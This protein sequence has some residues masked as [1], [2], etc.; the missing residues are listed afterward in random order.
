MGRGG[1]KRQG[2]QRIYMQCN[3]L[4]GKHVLETRLNRPHFS[5]ACVRT[6]QQFLCVEN[7]VSDN[8][9]IHVT[10]H[11]DEDVC[12]CQDDGK[13]DVSNH[14]PVCDKCG[15]YYGAVVRCDA[16]DTICGVDNYEVDNR[17][18]TKYRFVL[19]RL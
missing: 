7:L 10:P 2:I 9:A 5:V 12:Q 18:D 14:S 3:M 15:K 13:F 16:L 17:L 19:C 8:M 4:P 6:C 1:K 11:A